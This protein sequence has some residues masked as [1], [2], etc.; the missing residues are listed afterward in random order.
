M[1]RNGIIKEIL[2]HRQRVSVKLINIANDIAARGRRHDNSYTGDVE[3]TLIEKII[4]EPD[5]K[6]YHKKLLDSLHAKNN[7]Y[8][9]DYHGGI[10]EMN[11]IQLLEFIADKIATIDERGEQLDLKSY[12]KEIISM[13]PPISFDLQYVIEHTIEYFIDRNGS[14]LRSLQKSEAE[15]GD[16]PTLADAVIEGDTSTPTGGMNYGA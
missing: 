6:E 4:K 1:N 10:E 16:A 3:I 11:M 2:L 9:P 12:Q 14:I 7:D 15:Y 8:L 5:K 13:L